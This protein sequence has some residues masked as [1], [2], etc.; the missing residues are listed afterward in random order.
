MTG[1]MRMVHGNQPMSDDGLP[2][3][4]FQLERYKPSK[5]PA[6]VADSYPPLL[7]GV[8]LSYARA[9][10]WDL[11]S[12]KTVEMSKELRKSGGEL[13]LDMIS[14]LTTLRNSAMMRQIRIDKLEERMAKAEYTY[15]IIRVNDDNTIDILESYDTFNEALEDQKN[16][17]YKN[18]DQVHIQIIPRKE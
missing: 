17:R 9:I 13:I 8:D 1:C 18:K 4:N 5:W 3:S 6:V 15:E 2:K 12:H 10:A 14:E 16:K 11:V 7:G